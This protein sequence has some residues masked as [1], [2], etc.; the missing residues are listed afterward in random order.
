MKI[1]ITF[2]VLIF[3]FTVLHPDRDNMTVSSGKTNC[4]KIE[5]SAI[6]GKPEKIN[7]NIL[8]T[9]TNIKADQI[10]ISGNTAENKEES[11]QI[12]QS[13]DYYFVWTAL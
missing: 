10:K 3:F 4:T 6:S 2:L 5:Q 7:D 8:D 12:Y 13:T 9:D 1:T 11:K